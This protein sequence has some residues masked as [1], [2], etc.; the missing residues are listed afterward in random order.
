LLGVERAAERPVVAVAGRVPAAASVGR[1][2]TPSGVCGNGRE[3]VAAP[4][5]LAQVLGARGGHQQHTPFRSATAASLRAA[6]GFSEKY[7]HFPRCSR[8][9][10][11]TS[12]SF[13]MWCETV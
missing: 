6:S 10:R 12:S 5:F 2:A 3:R 4:D 1:A 7:A 9:T 13:F 8:S 11:P